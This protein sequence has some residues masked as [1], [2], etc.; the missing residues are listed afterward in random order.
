M[1]DP[2]PHLFADPDPHFKTKY[3]N[4]YQFL[5]ELDPDPDPYISI[6]P[7]LDP[8]KKM[9]IRNLDQ[10]KEAA[11]LYSLF[12]KMEELH[13]KQHQII[14]T[15]ENSLEGSGLAED[16]PLVPLG[17]QPRFKLSLVLFAQN[18]LYQKTCCPL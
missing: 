2:D 13:E 16:C 1:P 3:C 15:L 4:F 6:Q 17:T 12:P 8:Q 9:R 10:K 7:D 5:E 11:Q 18:F 14:T